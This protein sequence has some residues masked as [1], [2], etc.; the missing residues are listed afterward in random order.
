M[1]H[2][3]KQ[4]VGIG[5]LLLIGVL[6]FLLNGFYNVSVV[7]A[8]RL[9]WLLEI[10][11]W[12][13]LPIFVYLIGSKRRWFTAA[14]LGFSVFIIN[15]SSSKKLGAYIL[16][17]IVLVPAIYWF[18]VELAS[19]FALPAA[20]S[21]NS[22]YYAVQTSG[23]Y[24]AAAVAFFAVTAGVVEEFYYRGMCRLL[25]AEDR[26]SKIFYVI[27]SSLIFASAHWEGGWHTL[28]VSVIMGA[29][30]ASAYLHLKNL[31]PLIA[32]HIAVDLFWLWA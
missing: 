3:Q 30:L 1:N 20:G 9:F 32:G 13:A 31:W 12:V 25:F 19:H 14:Q 26:S 11:T 27:A 4:Q 15:E 2:R 18:A 21:F 7:H 22:Y 28:S 17:G 5:L 16:L 23:K 29:V 24:H 8:P 10:Y 6:P